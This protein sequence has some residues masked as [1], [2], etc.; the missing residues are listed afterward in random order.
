MEFVIG[1]GRAI[2]FEVRNKSDDK[3]LGVVV[4]AS[5][6][7]SIECRDEYIGWDKNLMMTE[8]MLK[9]TAVM[10][11][12]IGVQPFSNNTLGCKMVAM[13][14]NEPVVRNTWKEKYGDDLVGITTTSLFGSY[15]VYNNIPT[16]KKMGRTKG[17]IMLKPDD[18]IYLWWLKYL[19]HR[20]PKKLEGM[21][22]CS[23]YK[24]KV[25]SIIYRLNGMT[26]MDAQQEMVR[27]VYFNSLYKNTSE[28]LRKEISSEDLV[29]DDRVEKGIDYILDWWK[30]KAIKR[31]T[32]L[33]NEQRQQTDIL[34]YGNFTDHEKL[35]Q[36]WLS[37]RGVR[38]Y[39]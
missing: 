14:T 26:E 34:W 18:E 9:H 33:Y 3:I 24:Q 20:F 8:K 32:K 35:F 27:G 11:S 12:C 37:S 4:L 31:F 2:R 21:R 6:V 39:E 19:K 22:G 15:S 5:D 13:M 7:P 29:L 30:P 16:W 17:R 25:L 38:Y 1:I 10:S 28:F 23:G 36:Q